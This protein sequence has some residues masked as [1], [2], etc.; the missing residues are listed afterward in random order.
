[1]GRPSPLSQSQFHE[2]LPIFIQGTSATMLTIRLDESHSTHP[3][4]EY[5]VDNDQ[6]I[7]TP[8]RSAYTNKQIFEHCMKV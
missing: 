3:L 4:I 8:Y 6:H 5:F 7:G 2:V 1:M